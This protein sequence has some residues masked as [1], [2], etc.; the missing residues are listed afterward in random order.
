MHRNLCFLL[1][2][3]AFAAWPLAGVLAAADGARAGD[4]ARVTV[5]DFGQ[6]KAVGR[7]ALSPDGRQVAYALEGRIYLVP[8]AGGEPRAVTTGGS[9]ASQPYWPRDGGTLYFI[10][11]RTGLNQLWKLPVESFGEAVQVT[12]LDRGVDSI[13]LSPDETR[14]LLSFDDETKD[15]E[16]AGEDAGVQTREPWVI[17][18]LHF[19]E[20]AGEGY[21]TQ[22][23]SEHLY[24]YDIA[25][26][27]LTQI[28][29][30]RYAE[31]DAAWS[32]DGKRVVFV[33]NRDDPDAGYETD[34]WTVPAGAAGGAPPMSA[35]VRLTEDKHVRSSP[36]WSPDGRSIAFMSAEDGVYGLN[37]LAVVPADGGD[38]RIL[39]A[40]LDRW[41]SSF[42]FSDDGRWIWFTFDN[43]GGTHLARLRLRDGEIER[44]IEGER[45]VTAF[46]VDRSGNA[47]ARLQHMNDA[48]DLWY[49]G[50][51]RPQRVTDVNG[52]YFASRAIGSKEKVT[53]TVADGAVVEAFVTKPPGFDA[54]RRYPTILKIH[55]GPVGQFTYGYDFA[56]QFFAANGYVV[57]EPNP[58]G[59]TGR[60]QDFVRAIYRTWGITDYPDVIGA[61]DHVIE[62]G[63]AD[64]ERLF[65]TGYSYGGYMTNVVIT[66]TDRFRAAASGAGHSMIAANYGHDIYQKWYNWEFGLPMENREMYDRLSPLLRASRVETPTIFLGGREDWNVP[67]LN[68]ELF[69]QALR[70]RGID[71]QL[72]VYP[73]THHGGWEPV[74]SKDYLER[75]VAWFDRYGGE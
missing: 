19:K 61:I 46:D 73:D 52:E 34:L 5:E 54:A 74:Y 26:Q 50:R 13:N 44:V 70:Y 25:A 6:L 38:T 63:Y 35:L 27:K 51:S 15:A 37:Q 71:T 4:A 56:S 48:A 23:P 16:P 18:G 69:Y 8:V 2:A 49:S 67:I 53:Y 64:P 10:S 65:V 39:T 7:P 29:T 72:V 40:D 31:S 20:D 22:P 55:G 58:R 68:A 3:V 28:T 43:H 33:S 42:E 21:L 66:E 75:I 9:S 11:D 45:N 17:T 60:G 14:L 36:K 24:V 59:S 1:S 32:P 47:V 57:V 62:L 12:H 30:G 41:L